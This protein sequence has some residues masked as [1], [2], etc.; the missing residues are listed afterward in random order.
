[1]ESGYRDD[2]VTH[3]CRLAELLLDEGRSPWIG[4]IREV[5]HRGDT[6][7]H[8]PLIPKRFPALTWNTHYVY[9]CDGEVYDPLAN[10][11]LP[12]DEYARTVF[13]RHIEIEMH[14]D[15]AA[16]RRLVDRGE[17]RI[18]FRLRAGTPRRN[19]LS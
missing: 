4:R 19:E 11:A 14:L 3:A 18:S 10:A 5:I 9:C 12:S 15:A 1:M 2:C 8:G 16:T 6:V 17:L 7:F 13:G